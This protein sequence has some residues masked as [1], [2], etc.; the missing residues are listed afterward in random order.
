MCNIHWKIWLILFII[1]S[2]KRLG[3]AQVTTNV[4]SLIGT[5]PHARTLPV[6][7]GQIDLD[8]G[9]MHLEIPLYSVPE[10][11]LQPNTVSL[12]YESFFW[13]STSDFGSTYTG[14][15]ALYPTGTGWSIGGSGGETFG[16]TPEQS[17]VSPCSSQRSGDSGTITTINRWS[18]A[19]THGTLHE[20]NLFAVQNTCTLST[21]GPDTATVP[22]SQGGLA[23]AI[24]GSGYRLTIASDGRTINL[25]APDGAQGVVLTTGSGASYKEFTG[26]E[27]PNGNLSGYFGYP[28]VNGSYSSYD[29]IGGPTFSI[30]C[31]FTLLSGSIAQNQPYVS[32]PPLTC[33]ATMPAWDGVNQETAT[34]QYSLTYEWAPVCTKLFSDTTQN[35]EY[36]GGTWLLQS[37]TLPGGLGSYQ[38]GYDTGTSGTHLGELT[39]IT[40]PTGGIV[41]YTYGYPANTATAEDT[42]VVTSV[43]DLG[44]TTTISYGGTQWNPYPETILFPPHL[45][46]PGGTAMVQDERTISAGSSST[47]VS[48]YPPYT[49]NDYSGSTLIRSTVENR[50]S[51][52]R[53]TSVSSTWTATGEN[54]TVNYKYADDPS[55][56]GY[57][58]YGGVPINFISQESEY[59]SGALVRTLTTQYIK[60]SSTNA[61]VSTYNMLDY[62]VSQTLTNASG[63]TIAQTL[64]TY[65]EYSTGYCESVYPIGLSGIPMLT[66]VSGAS[67]HDDGRGTSYTARGN[68]TTIQRMVSPGAYV[69]IHKCYDTL[70]NVLQTVD[71][72]NRATRYGY[73][74][75]YLDTACIASGINTNAFPTLV[76]NPFGQ[77]V[78][79]AYYSC[80]RAVGQLQSANDLSNGRSGTR[81]EYDVAGRLHCTTH[82]D[83]SQACMTYPNDNEI[84]ATSELND[85]SKAILDGY[86]RVTSNIDTSAAVEV[87]TSYDALGHTNCFSNPY[88]L[89]GIS[90]GNTCYAYDALSR[91]TGILYADGARLSNSYSGNSATSTDPNGNQ[92]TKKTDSLGR[93]RFVW[94]P[95]GASQSPS[96]E[97]DYSYDALNNLSGV[98]QWGGP[99]GSSGARS[100]SF[101]YDGMSHLLTAQNPETGSTCYGVWSGGTCQGGYDGDSNLVAKTDARGA[102]INYSYDALN[103]LTSKTYQN[104]P[105]GTLSSCYQYDTATSGIGY[106]AREWTQSGSCV[107]SPPTNSPSVRTIGGY[108]AM[109]RILIEQQCAAGYCTS[110]SMPQ[111]PQPNCTALSSAS[112]LQYCYDF[113]GNL[114]AFSNGVSTVTAGSYPQQAILSSQTFDVAGR[115]ANVNSSWSDSTHPATL[116]SNATYA[117]NNALSTWLLGTSLWMARQYDNRLRLCNQQSATQQVSPSPCQ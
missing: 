62:P 50:D 90:S 64:Y 30:P 7:F 39:S 116:F 22:Q 107:S 15:T 21:G 78:A 42:P 14:S 79:T 49:V 106:L 105:A 67:G 17:Q 41:G 45:V 19:D 24:D 40:L 65:D 72:N 57:Q 1:A 76:T 109:G 68:I 117:P 71:G 93:L 20:F 100:R 53:I 5:P 31:T 25:A 44:G 113:A 89:G 87:D 43:A 52:N 82:S 36:C 47:S 108:D 6:R 9:E 56:Q 60:D 97:T 10:R 96:M 80:N 46:T 112:G 92:I 84:D 2:Y 91:V 73:Q 88:P 35:N 33:T 104:A 34:A 51:A 48:P 26:D 111:S 55:V 58:S 29:E 54:H 74:D 94:E 77:Q 61:Y 103:R 38:F 12:A 66:S 8:S 23:Y 83:G 63:S 102:I 110:N 115:L 98:T 28:I 95:N 11:G 69:T 59:D 4:S 13:H 85:L 16:V 3:E 114:L 18:G 101:T 37:V 70:G 86:G 75:D 27:T 32:K 81:T 99:N